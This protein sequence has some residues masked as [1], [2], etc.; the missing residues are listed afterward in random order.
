VADEEGGVNLVLRD[1]TVGLLGY[2]AINQKVHKHLQSF[3]V[4]FAILRKHWDKQREPLLTEALRF[5]ENEL[6]PF[7]EATDILIIGLP[8]TSRT[9]G[10]IGAD[11]LKLLGESSL[12]VNVAR[13]SIV[14][15]EALY[16]ALEDGVIAGA[17]LDVWYEYRPEPDEQ[18]RLYPYHFPF[19]GLDNVVLSPHRAASPVYAPDRWEEVVENILHFH[20]GEPL[21]NVVD[22]TEEY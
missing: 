20:Q 16:H 13:G 17:A 1:Q 9:L 8:Q 15:E 7:L 2:G 10:L 3:G 14:D 19:H 4:R 5:S 21:I 12:L 22:L 18:G 6:A 11:E